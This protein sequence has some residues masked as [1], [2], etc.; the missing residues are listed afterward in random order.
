[1]KTESINLLNNAKV[2]AR[3]AYSLSRW[4]LLAVGRWHRLTEHHTSVNIN[5]WCWNIEQHEVKKVNKVNDAV[6]TQKWMEGKIEKI[7]L[8]LFTWLILYF[9]TKGFER[10][11]WYLLACYHQPWI[12]SFFVYNLGNQIKCKTNSILFY[13]YWFTT[14][15]K[16]VIKYF[17]VCFIVIFTINILKA[18]RL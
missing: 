15:L 9:M 8:F 18:D 2:S 14:V 6:W 12:L 1:M 16:F 17:E 7:A 3:S 10:S 13:V 11:F 5:K 4:R